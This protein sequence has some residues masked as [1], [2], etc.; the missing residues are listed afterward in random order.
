M[1]LREGVCQVRRFAIVDAP[2]IALHERKPIKRLV[3]RAAGVQQ[4]LPIPYAGEIG[5]AGIRVVEPAILLDLF[6]SI[7]GV[8]RPCFNDLHRPDTPDRLSSCAKE[9]CRRG[10]YHGLYAGAK[11][12]VYEASLQQLV[13]KIRPRV[14][15]SR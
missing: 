4:I 9:D 8:D 6:G 13:Y 12:S 10:T 5:F 2:R 1:P 3:A 7:R 15:G 14:S 11:W